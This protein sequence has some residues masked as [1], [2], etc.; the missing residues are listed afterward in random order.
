MPAMSKDEIE[1]R[2]ADEG[3]PYLTVF[4]QVYEKQF[5]VTASLWAVTKLTINRKLKTDKILRK[6]CIL[7]NKFWVTIFMCLV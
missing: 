1:S 6:V 4:A 7:G 2:F 5:K 3:I